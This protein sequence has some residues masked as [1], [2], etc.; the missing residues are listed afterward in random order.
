LDHPNNRFKNIQR[1]GKD[2]YAVFTKGNSSNTVVEAN[3][4]ENCF[5]GASF[6]AGGFG[7]NFFR[8]L[9][10][11]YEQRYGIIR[12][13]IIVGC[14]DAAIYITKGLECKI[15]N[16]TILNCL[17][18]IQLRYESSGLVCNNLVKRHSNNTPEPLVR[19]R[20][21]AV[22]IA[23]K[24][25][26]EAHYDDFVDPLKRQMDLHLS[27]KSRAIGAGVDLGKDVP[28][29]FEGIQRPQGDGFDVGAYEKYL[30]C[31]APSNPRAPKSTEDNRYLVFV[32]PHYTFIL[33]VFLIISLARLQT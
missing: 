33:S 15:F 6:G 5:I 14:M 2:A 9:D 11:S 8:D 18:T 1:N 19:L 13:N 28:T 12:N 7:D 16:N 22:L 24:A 29:D 20:N 23:D 17:L 32:F 21:G 27:P 26:L 10:S 31:T 3:Y 25:N 4:F 30:L